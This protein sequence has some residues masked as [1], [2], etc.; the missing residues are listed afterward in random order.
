MPRTRARWQHEMP[1]AVACTEKR[2]TRGIKAIDPHAIGAE[3]GHER[4]FLAPR[5]EAN[6]MWMATL[7]SIPQRGVGCGQR[8][9]LGVDSVADSAVGQDRQDDDVRLRIVGDQHPRTVRGQLKMCRVAKRICAARFSQRA[10]LRDPQR[11]EPASTG[12]VQVAIGR[13]PGKPADV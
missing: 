3:V 2:P 6:L 12:R 1:R 13:V 8:V 10:I 11:Y 5:I 9:M 4:P 7:L